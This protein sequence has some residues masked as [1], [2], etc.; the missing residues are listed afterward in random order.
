MGGFKTSLFIFS[1]ICISILF[2]WGGINNF[3]HWSQFAE[4]F[5]SMLFEWQMYS[6]GKIFLENLF[7]FAFSTS[8]V[9]LGIIT[10]LQLL[11][12]LMIFLGLKVR[13]GAI[14]IVIFLI[15]T[16]IFYFP[17]WMQVGKEFD[18]QLH[19]FF[20]NLSIL[21]SLLYISL[22]ERSSENMDQKKRT[23]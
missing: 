6:E 22:G 16:T 9:I 3:F 13:V 18:T 14:F 23:S 15:P 19:L 20:K 11:G 1:R 21:G 10:S 4:D 5:T 12:G 7:D 8:S 2:I 17:F